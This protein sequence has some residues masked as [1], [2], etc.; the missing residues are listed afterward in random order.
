[1]A[2][3]IALQDSS[4]AE[5]TACAT[6]GEAITGAEACGFRSYA[7]LAVMLFD[8]RTALLGQPVH[9][10]MIENDMSFC[11]ERIEYIT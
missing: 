11:T 2:I 6:L 8:P 3:R 4:V 5:I 9:M 7:E 1:L 10:Q